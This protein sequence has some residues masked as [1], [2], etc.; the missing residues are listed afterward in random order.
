M[1]FVARKTILQTVVEIHLDSSG[2]FYTQVDGKT[3]TGRHESLKQAERAARTELKKD[4]VRV[5]VPFTY[6]QGEKM[7][8]AIS[9]GFHAADKRKI[10]IWIDDGTENGK[11]E[12]LN[13]WS[14]NKVL[15]ADIPEQKMR[16]IQKLF[17]RRRKLS[18]LT[19][20]CDAR[21][22]AWEEEFVFNISDATRIAVEE[23][24]NKEPDTEDVDV[25]APEAESASALIDE[26]LKDSEA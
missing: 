22:R 4:Q 3:F 11:N 19:R 15:R 18:E 8:P 7:Y 9:R 5:A 17:E 26:L 10:L 23:A 21:I 24:A 16:W 13:Y 6:M 20:D 12:T 1:T 25:E 2:L 14:R